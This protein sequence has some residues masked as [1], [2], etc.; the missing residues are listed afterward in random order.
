MLNTSNATHAAAIHSKRTINRSLDAPL[1]RGDAIQALPNPMPRMKAISTIANDCN[2][3]PKINA[4]DRDDNT[5][6]PIDTAP[7][8]ATIAPAQ[9][10][11][12]GD[13]AVNGA[14]AAS[15]SAARSATTLELLPDT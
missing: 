6:S 13:T 11:V 4:S 12:S 3:E 10:K 1:R 8:N 14:G 15:T 5:S 7:V 9:R 2:D